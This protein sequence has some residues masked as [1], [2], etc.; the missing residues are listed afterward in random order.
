ML[1][2]K[3]VLKAL[4]VSVVLAFLLS[5]G[6]AVLFGSGVSF[7]PALDWE[8][9]DSMPYA[10]AN[11]YITTHTKP[12]SG[13]E[14]LKVH[15]GWLTFFTPSFFALIGSFFA[16]CVVLLWWVGHEN[17]ITLRSRPTR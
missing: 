17:D 8:K 9:V 11:S 16:G 7:D 12:M 15:V 1:N 2:G 14:M 10:E 4:V 3:N 6:G 5:V 13:W